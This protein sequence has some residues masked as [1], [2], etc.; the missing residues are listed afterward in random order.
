[1]GRGGAQRGLL[2]AP[3]GGGGV[4]ARRDFVVKPGEES[5]S[6]GIMQRPE[7]NQHITNARHVSG[8]REVV[9]TLTLLR[10]AC[11]TVARSQGEKGG[12]A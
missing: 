3:G 11:A 12:A 5:R 6:C 9:N 4:G 10:P 2:G 8:P 1:M 7:R